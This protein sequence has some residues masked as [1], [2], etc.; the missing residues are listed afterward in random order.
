MVFVFPA[1]LSH[2]DNPAATSS[3]KAMEDSRIRVFT[4]IFFVFGF[5][6]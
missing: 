5:G 6:G 2:E 1:V 4:F 3:A